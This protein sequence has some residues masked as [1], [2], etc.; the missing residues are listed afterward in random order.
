MSEIGHVSK[1]GLLFVRVELYG[2]VNTVKVMSS[3]S[4]NPGPAEPR[5]AP[6]L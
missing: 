5:Y 4:I 3:R 6:S 1:Q 2:P